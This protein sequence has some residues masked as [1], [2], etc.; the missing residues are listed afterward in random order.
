MRLAIAMMEKGTN[1]VWYQ[2]DAEAFVRY[3]ETGPVIKAGPEGRV[4]VSEFS[5]SMPITT[6]P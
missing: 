1:M 4:I 5:L 3:L 2:G 6:T